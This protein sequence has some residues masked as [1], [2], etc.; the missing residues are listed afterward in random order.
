MSSLP[1]LPALRLLVDVARLG[2]IG[3]AGR[4]AGISQQSASERLRAVETQT[5]LSLVQ[6]STSGST[7]TAH[8]RLLVEWSQD[9][10]DRA[11]ELD[12]A[13][14]TLRSEG[15]RELHV[16]ASM[17]TAEFLLPRWLVR[18]RQQSAAG[19]VAPVAVSLHA[20]N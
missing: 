14:R 1:D 20:T 8:G 15:T 18:L 2:S 11:D 7:L 3:A 13:V 4:A 9:L 6:R 17:T 5:G 16:Y 19:T 10:L 12:L